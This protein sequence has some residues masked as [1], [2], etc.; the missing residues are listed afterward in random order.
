MELT[1][2]MSN[3]K[4]ER[5]F[6]KWPRLLKPQSLYSVT[7]LFQAV[8]PPS[9]PK[10]SWTGKQIFK[11]LRLW[12]LSHSHHCVSCLSLHNFDYKELLFKFNL[13]LN[14]KILLKWNTW[15]F[16]TKKEKILYNENFKAQRKE[17]VYTRR[18]KCE[19]ITL[20][21]E[22][23]LVGDLMLELYLFSFIQ[24]IYST[25]SLFSVY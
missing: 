24:T 1:I 10:Q 13:E 22:K 4:Q 21:F 18:W 15:E 20:L 9:S 3:R 16:S 12:K 11:D 8:K 25:L 14:K 5:A 2:A 23:E 17:M 6:S 7:Y 19:N